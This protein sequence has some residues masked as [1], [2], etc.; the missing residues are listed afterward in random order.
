MPD[1]EYLARARAGGWKVHVEAGRVT[2]MCPSCGRPD[3]ALAALA[4][5][6]HQ[7]VLQQGTFDVP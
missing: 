4:R 1:A 5:E 3:R 2:A 7:S 6:L